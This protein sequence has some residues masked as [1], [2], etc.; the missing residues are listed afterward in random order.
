M[1]SPVGPNWMK[2]KAK[3]ERKAARE[4]SY[5]AENAAKEAADA[6]FEEEVEKT[7]DRMRRYASLL[8][9]HDTDYSDEHSD[10]VADYVSARLRQAAHRLGLNP[11]ELW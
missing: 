9:S 11:D 1:N 5:A 2:N 10:A 3:R 4:E 7:F 6:P 8:R